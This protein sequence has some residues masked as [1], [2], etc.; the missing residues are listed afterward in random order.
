[1]GTGHTGSGQLGFD[2]GELVVREDGQG[3]RTI[4]AAKQVPQDGGLVVAEV[5]G[6]LFLQTK[7]K[8]CA[9]G[10]FAVW[11]HGYL[12]KVDGEIV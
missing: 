7:G 10:D 12:S 5:L 6:F 3:Q 8:Q 4:L 9:D 11:S 1:M 2:Q